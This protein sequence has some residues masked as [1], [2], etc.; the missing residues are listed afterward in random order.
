MR[1]WLLTHAR[2]AF[3]LWSLPAALLLIWCATQF[4]GS[5]LLILYFLFITWVMAGFSAINGL[6]AL[7]RKPAFRALDEG[8][9]PEPLL[10]LCRTVLKQNPKSLYYRVFEGW[11]LS[12]LG[13]GDDAAEAARLA[14]EQPRLWKDP[15]L[16]AVWLTPVSPGDPLYAKGEAALARLSRRLSP[17]RRAVLERAETMRARAAQAETAAPELEPLL[18]DDLARASCTRE[19]VAAHLALGVYYV[20][21]N[22]PAAEEHLTFAAEHGNKLHARTE[23]ERLLCLLPG[24]P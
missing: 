3:W 19:R 11:A 9:D 16:L 1:T 21:R 10:D 4:G 24:S 13:R 2:A 23:A 6:S 18:L 15:R 22:D 14:A 7:A 17:K 5:A 20:Q 12:L 8:C